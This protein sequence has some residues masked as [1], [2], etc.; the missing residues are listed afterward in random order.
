MPLLSAAGLIN[1]PLG[2]VDISVDAGECVA[3]Q[4]PSG[5]GKTLLLR[6]LADLDPSAGDVRLEGVSRAAIPGPEWRRRVGHVPAEPGWWS[7][8]PVAHLEDVDAAM[9]ELSRLGLDGAVLRRPVAQLSTGERQRLALIRALQRNPRVLLLDEPTA[10]L[11][12]EATHTVERLIAERQAAGTGV[13]WVTHDRPQVARVASRIVSLRAGRV[14]TGRVETGRVETGRVETGRS[15]LGP[16][17]S[18]QCV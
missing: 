9:V 14:E 10:A 17:E 12:P 8:D 15:T 4:G 3:V 16:S 18:E 13:L 2:P 11:D 6:A 7:D 1:G 5:S